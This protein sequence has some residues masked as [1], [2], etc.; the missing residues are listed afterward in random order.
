VFSGNLLLFF[1][2][3]VS[4]WVLFHSLAPAQALFLSEVLFGS[5]ENPRVK[6]R[7]IVFLGNFICFFRIS[8]F[9]VSSLS[10]RLAL[11]LGG[12]LF[13]SQE[14]FFLVFLFF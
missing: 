8:V 5:C 2:I 12:V 14:F 1:R 13:G 7:G 9:D 3:C 10:H 4:L 6:W 11:F